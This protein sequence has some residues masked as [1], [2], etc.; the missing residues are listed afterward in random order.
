MAFSTE[1]IPGATFSGSAYSGVDPI[2]FNAG[3]VSVD[4]TNTTC[5]NDGVS[6]ASSD[7]SSVSDDET[8]LAINAE[9][10]DTNAEVAV[11][12]DTIAFA[13]D[14]SPPAYQLAALPL[15]SPENPIEI[16]DED[17]ANQPRNNDE[18]NDYERLNSPRFDPVEII[19]FQ[20]TVID[21]EEVLR[22]RDRISRWFLNHIRHNSQRV[23]H[24]RSRH[25]RAAAGPVET[26]W[27]TNELME[28]VLEELDNILNNASRVELIHI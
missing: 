13:S 12:N 2:P 24:G 20:A 18:V 9:T 14:D 5:L 21:E 4:D 25:A 6:I 22:A 23:L 15:G 3:A 10:D 7:E 11:L 16:E 1:W 19:P 27:T 8:N 26:Y 28:S 17:V